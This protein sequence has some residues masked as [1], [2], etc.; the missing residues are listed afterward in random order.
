MSSSCENFC[1]V[2]SAAVN[3]SGSA[4]LHVLGAPGL[5]VGEK[6]LGSTGRVHLVAP[7]ILL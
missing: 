2:I 1:A 4:P 6:I 3:G 5:G 7:C